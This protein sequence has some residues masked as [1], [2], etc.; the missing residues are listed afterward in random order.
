[1]RQMTFITIMF[2]M[3]IFF[4]IAGSSSELNDIKEMGY[5]IMSNIWVAGA[6]IVYAISDYKR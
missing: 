2:L 3:G 1:M 6:A 4:L 5:A